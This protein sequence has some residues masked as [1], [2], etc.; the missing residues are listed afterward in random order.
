MMGRRSPSSETLIASPRLPQLAKH[1]PGPHRLHWVGAIQRSNDPGSITGYDITA[2]FVDMSQ[3]EQ[4]FINVALPLTSLPHLAAGS[5]WRNQMFSKLEQ[6]RTATVTVDM[7]KFNPERHA[8]KNP[9][10]LIPPSV[11]AL[12]PVTHHCW[13]RT[14]PLIDG[15][16]IVVPTWEI[17]R[18]AYFF[19][20]RL[21]PPF[22]GGALDHPE[23]VSPSILP[24]RPEETFR[25]SEG[26]VQIGYPQFIGRS[27]ALRL[28]RLIFDQDA[29]DGLRHIYRSIRRDASEGRTAIRV[30]PV[31]PPFSTRGKWDIR[32]IDI[33]PFRGAGRRRLVLSI[34]GINH[35]LPYRSVIP[36][37]AND[38]RSTADKNDSLPQI[39]RPQSKLILPSHG[40]LDLYG[41]AGD[42][43][44]QT[45]EVMGLELK[46]NATEVKTVLLF[47]ESQTH[48]S[49]GHNN[50]PATEVND[51][52]L[53][54]TGVPT[55]GRP[56]LAAGDPSLPKGARQ[57]SEDSDA[58]EPIDMGRV[59]SALR[60][61]L[62]ERLSGWTVEPFGGS[63]GSESGVIRI[64]DEAMMKA[65]SFLVLHI[66]HAHRHLYL[67]DAEKL[68]GYEKYRVLICE[69]PDGTP[70]SLS[71]FI[72]WL[73]KFPY[74]YGRHWLDHDEGG[75][76]LRPDYLIHQP[77]TV[78]VAE[79]TI[80]QRFVARL[81][82][83][84]LRFIEGP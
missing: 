29:R 38:A 77:R 44:L 57:T 60:K 49:G 82:P 40:G 78:G 2:W 34:H 5:I 61:S 46:D 39:H 13:C 33:P 73:G 28:A 27:L 69:T 53:D 14:L 26:E 66:H 16:E 64:H 21:I 84:V 7:T 43:N 48:R 30:P 50:E 76:L 74:P 68:K 1:G 63:L 10:L 52:A 3:A 47:K 9:Y 36:V 32:Y 81:V 11:Y 22:L 24:W 8:A 23:T 15:S 31:R 54:S 17:L 58:I 79:E 72:E 45:V 55:R 80:R 59:F 19:H 42:S 12:A 35:A 20:P 65:R 83:F 71:M 18:T 67:I 75:L 25:R 70:I 56:E 41:S 62:L 4:K 51:V 6:V 37:A